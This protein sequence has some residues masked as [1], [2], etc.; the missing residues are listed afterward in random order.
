MT[1]RERRLP[2]WAQEELRAVRRENRR[3]RDHIEA[4]EPPDA[5]TFAD[6]YGATTGLPPRRALGR[7]TKVSFYQTTDTDDWNSRVDVR[8]EGGWL[9]VYG[10]RSLIVIPESGNSIRLRSE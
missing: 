10:G 9:K 8:V 3:L 2:K 1:E 7:G 6:D 5:D 4:N